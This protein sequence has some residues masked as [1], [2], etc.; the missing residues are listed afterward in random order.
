MEWT[1]QELALLK[2]EG[3]CTCGSPRYGKRAKCMQCRYRAPYIKSDDRPKFRGR[4]SRLSLGVNW[5]KVTEVMRN[6]ILR[7]VAEG[8]Q[9]GGRIKSK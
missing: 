9:V 3:L 8:I 1:E 4:L 6:E 7:Q 2:Q 5:R